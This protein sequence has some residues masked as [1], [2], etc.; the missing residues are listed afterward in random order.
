M[1]AAYGVYLSGSG[2]I[3]HLSIGGPPP[4]DL[5]PITEQMKRKPLGLA[6]E[7]VSFEVDASPTRGDLYIGYASFS[8]SLNHL[9]ICI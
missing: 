9:L 2:D 7:H 3:D 5:A 8:G 1:L 4:E 6:S